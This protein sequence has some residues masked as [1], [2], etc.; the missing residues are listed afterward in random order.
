MKD[1]SGARNF[2]CFPRIS[3]SG[4]LYR[5]GTA[6]VLIGLFIIL[7]AT[8]DLIW[9]SRK[10]Y[11][12]THTEP[13][14]NFTVL[15]P[16]PTGSFFAP[17]GG[18]LELHSTL[19]MLL[20]RGV[21]S[22]VPHRLAAM[23]ILAVLAAV[24]TLWLNWRIVAV[25]F[26]RAAAAVCLFLLVTS[27]IYLESM[28][29]FG[30]QSLSQLA[31]ILTIYFAAA[32]RKSWAPA[33]AAAAAFLV[34]Q[35]YVAARPVIAF[36]ALF[37]LFNLRSSWRRLLLYLAVLVSLVTAVGL[38]EKRSLTYPWRYFA[39]PEVQAGIWPVV[40]G[41]VNWDDL[42]VNL[43]RNAGLAAEYLLNLRR[44]PFTARESSSRLIG[45]FYTPFLLLG[46]FGIWRRGRPGRNTVLLMVI[47]FFILPLASREIQPRRILIALYPISLLITV[48]MGLVYR[49]FR[50][51]GPLAWLAAGAL[52]AS[53]GRDIHEFLFSVSRP[54]L[55]YPRPGLQ[56]VARFVEE[57][58]REVSHIR[59]YR[60]IDEL[61]MGNP[62]FLPR[63]GKP[64]PAANIFAEE[65][66]DLG[67]TLRVFSGRVGED[68]IYLYTDPPRRIDPA[69]IRWAEEQFGQIVRRDQVPGTDNLYYLRV[70]LSRL[71]PNLIFRA[72][73]F[74]RFRL[75]GRISSPAFAGPDDRF[76]ETGSLP[77]LFDGDA[78]TSVSIL[79][80]AAGRPIAIDFELGEMIDTPVRSVSFRVPEGGGE[81]FFRR[82]DFLG[83]G[84]DGSWEPLAEFVVSRP[85]EGGEWLNFEFENRRVRSRYR[86]EMVGGTWADETAPLVLAGIWMF[87][88]RDRELKIEEILGK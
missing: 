83:L 8:P 23:R 76:R 62:Y 18:G 77:E 2:P 48:G 4:L 14:K 6:A 21:Y 17:G 26:S 82:A 33:A 5:R 9:A 28:R 86:L 44:S 78:G 37:Y 68:L 75:Q 36:P 49:W 84:D 16:V 29:A 51:R 80:P 56:S 24:L 66:V 1:D 47:L 30:Y 11:F 20:L 19:Y 45:P 87:D 15:H 65:T 79:P 88:R 46:L 59:Y 12:A 22:L 27:P 54:R 32:S 57:K 85:P 31:V 38:A 64:V 81:R 52:L 3:P 70:E 53:G 63:P 61:I 25:L 74:C 43:A 41:R 7:T 40:G 10:S 39:S 34:L 50:G 42:K 73:E 69:T 72:D 60:E 55:N 35:L 71:A 13:F 58:W 67:R